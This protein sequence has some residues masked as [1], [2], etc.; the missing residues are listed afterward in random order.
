[1]VV[2][3]SGDGPAGWGPAS[4]GACRVPDQRFVRPAEVDLLIGDRAKVEADLGWTPTGHFE[5]L[6]QMMVDYG[7]ARLDIVGR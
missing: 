7:V 1:M 5:Q 2:I 3:E 6:V 4:H